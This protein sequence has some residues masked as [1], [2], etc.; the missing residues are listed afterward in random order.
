[1]RTYKIFQIIFEIPIDKRFE[2]CYDIAAEQEH[3]KYFTNKQKYFT[4]I[5]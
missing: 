1:M 4:E 3:R 2:I 5:Y